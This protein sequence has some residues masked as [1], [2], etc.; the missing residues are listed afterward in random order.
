MNILNVS[1]P[2][3]AL[4]GPWSTNINL[5]SIG[6]RIALSMLCSA[7]LGCERASKRHTAGLRSFILISLSA[8]AAMLIDLTLV[9]YTGI[10]IFVI[11]AAS[12]VAVAVISVNS[13]LFSSKSQ[14]KGFTTSAGLWACA[15]LG[16]AIGAGFYSL[17]LILFLALYLCLSKFPYFEQILKD[18]SNHFEVHIELAN[19][20]SLQNFVTTIRELGLRVDDIESN[21]A[22]ANSG[23]SVYSVSISIK[24]DELRK[25]KSH[26]EIIA[27]IATLEYVRHIEEMN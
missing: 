15:V 4:M 9:F 26:K 2:I 18:R 17:S 3:A 19:P 23:L 7:I 1:D 22:Y 12:V 24:S 11:S 16:L 13:V 8:T 25:Y 27:A 20:K 6:L 10:T 14:I 21:P 5:A